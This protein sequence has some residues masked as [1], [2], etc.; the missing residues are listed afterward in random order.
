MSNTAGRRTPEQIREHYEIEKALADRLRHASRAERAGLYAEVY[1]ELFRSVPH[2]PQLTR[3]KD[4]KARAAA[5]ALQLDY[6]R[7]FLGLDVRFLEIGAGDCGLAGAAAKFVKSS[8]ALEVAREIALGSARPPNMETRLFD[9]VNIPLPDN[10]IHVAYSNQLVEHL[11]PEDALDHMK[12]V[13]RVMAPGGR[14]VCITPNRLYGPHDISRH[15]DKTATG[16]HLKEYTVGELNTIMRQAGFSRRRIIF[17]LNASFK[18]LSA[19]W[20]AFLETCI[21]GTP[22]FI[23]KRILARPPVQCLLGIKY[24]A[25]K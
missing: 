5:L 8:C 4:G 20:T 18:L 22:G 17:N 23:R 7:P 13:F 16:L 2:H 25:V 15:F 6:I 9:G 10:S 19:S 14:Y 11:H 12:S 21:K 24:I 3:K 1:N